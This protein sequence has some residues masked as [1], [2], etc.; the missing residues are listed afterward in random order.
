[1]LGLS[2]VVTQATNGTA[3]TTPENPSTSTTRDNNMALWSSLALLSSLV[4]ITLSFPDESAYKIP[5]V[6]NNRRSQYYVLHNDGTYKYGYDTGEGAFEAA[7][8]H[9]R[10]RQDGQFGYRDPEGNAVSLQYEAGEGGFQATGS[11]I[12]QAHP[13]FHTAHAAA[14][15]RPPFVDPLAN[16]RSDASYG[17]RFVEDGQAREEQSDAD[18][19]VRGSYTYTDEEGQTRTISYVAG[20]DTGFVVT[21]DDLPQAPLAPGATPAATTLSS[22]AASSAFR[23]A[24]YRPSTT[25][26]SH[27][28]SSFSSSS[29]RP[30]TS[31]SRFTGTSSTT[32]YSG[33][34]GARTPAV[35]TSHTSA[36][37]TP[38]ISRPSTSSAHSSL[39]TTRFGSTRQST[40]PVEVANTRSQITPGGGYEVAYQT[41]SHSRAESG[42][43]ANNVDGRFNFVAEDDGQRR[44]I[45]YEAGSDTG[46]IAE[47]A[48]I[49]VG[50]EVPG[51]PSGQP[52]GRIV[53]VQ[54]VPF[55]D[56]LAD[57]NT[58]ASYSF[59]FESEQYSRTESAD[60]D[61]N[62]Q[63]T[64]TVVD[65]D[66][67]RRTYRFRA[68]QGVGY[69]AEEVS[70]TRGAAPS[71]AAAQAGATSFFN[72]AAGVSTSHTGG[73]G[74]GIGAG[75][76]VGAGVGA[77]VR[78][79]VG[80]GA[81][82]FSSTTGTASRVPT[83][84]GPVISYKT[85]TTFSHTGGSAGASHTRTGGSAGAS[86]TRTGG[87]AGASH[88]RTGSIS[89]SH[90]GSSHFGR[91]STSTFSTGG[92]S[93][94]GARRTPV[95]TS[96]TSTAAREVFPGFKLRQY[97]A[98][99]AKGKYGYVLTFD[100]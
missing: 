43:A 17:F 10:G 1:M 29:F 94:T 37:R 7:R 39:S 52:T 85:P 72:N 74:A 57:S 13:D 46:F 93:F 82:S 32:Q 54:E 65:D 14:R 15:A 45:N 73:V 89:S 56:P 51:A 81:T 77:G 23:G 20:S 16:T 19:N 58:D 8:L 59:G 21:G 44:E 28:G 60:A 88:T 100:N 47:G 97:G 70:S 90:T 68:G 11:H 78:P 38:T 42:D 18:G 98:N 64:Y 40:R 75:V 76:G 2:R 80:V 66:G 36:Y 3:S 95:S 12:P 92:S 61:G 6:G 69:E 9:H 55:I 26:S 24:S 31:G 87:S 30:S 71:K 50:P 53:P 62:V 79:G 35:S 67:T 25:S 27:R 83:A 4:V 48:H 91:G 41:S 22:G 63:G 96:F 84:A 49:P 86:H 34:H 99:E 5:Q 33:T